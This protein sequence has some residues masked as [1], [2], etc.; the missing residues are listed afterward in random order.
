MQII[1]GGAYF[2]DKRIGF[3][4]NSDFCQHTVHW[5]SILHKRHDQAI[6]KGPYFIVGI[7]KWVRRLQKSCVHPNKI[8]DKIISWLMAN[9]E[10]GAPMGV[11]DDCNLNNEIKVGDILRKKLFEHMNCKVYLLREYLANKTYDKRV[12]PFSIPCKDNT[13]MLVLP[14]DKKLDIYFQ[15]DDSSD[16][17]K[18]MLKTITTFPN[19]K[20]ILYKNGEKSREKIPYYDFLKKLASTKICP[21]FAGAG[22]CTFRY[23]EVAS[24]GS[25]I[26]IPKYPW[27]VRNDYINGVSCIK[28]DKP[29]E[30]LNYL[31]DKDRLAEM[32]HNSLN[33]F[34]KYHTTE[35]R[36][37]EFMEYADVVCRNKKL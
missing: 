15:G 11:L 13:K 17:R 16:D 2:T 6:K 10:H 8:P 3:F 1:I 36:Y 20:V 34:L 27:I 19:S 35:I 22:Y 14:E 9:C 5:E 24:V 32:Q 28:Y 21:V 30:M 31:E 29:E 18:P 33:H 23:Q 4:E 25:I 12:I 37:Q 7:K 26:A